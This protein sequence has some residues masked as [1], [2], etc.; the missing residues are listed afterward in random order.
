MVTSL[1]RSRSDGNA[2]ML[3]TGKQRKQLER[4][5]RKYPIELADVPASAFPPGVKLPPGCFRVLRS[6]TFL[7]QLFTTPQPGV[8]RLS[9]NR[10]THNGESWGD[11]ITWD[12]LQKLKREAGYGDC[13]A[14]EC[15]PRDEDVVNVTNMRHLMV[16]LVD[17]PA[18]FWRK[19]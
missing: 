3:P 11:N 12:E 13:D 8:V 4:D 6:R 16:F 7:V 2:S 1:R 9:V 15:Y 19:P 5:N 18:Y 17:R 10:T 14:V